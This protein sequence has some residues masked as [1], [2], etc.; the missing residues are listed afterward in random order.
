[1]T[2]Y[3]LALH[4]ST[5]E[6]GLAIG[7]ITSHAD[8]HDYRMNVWDLG[9]ETSNV[10][11]S[12]IAEFMASQQWRDLGWIA[13]ARGPGGFTGTRLAVVTA[14][15]ICQ[16]LQIPLYGISNLAAVAWQQQMLGDIA[17]AMPGQQGQ[18]YSGTYRRHHEAAAN[19]R[20]FLEV[21]ENDQLTTTTV[22]QAYSD[23]FSGHKIILESG[24]KLG[25]TVDSVWDLAALQWRQGTTSSWEDLTPF[26]G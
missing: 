8:R 11:H 22:W 13:V 5:P 4:S 18:I 9:R 25:N 14:K 24:A 21:L 6:L 19:D 2:K 12:Y 17:V 10:L 20:Q 3:G 16:Q 23:K 15:T 7:P 1:M 26:Y